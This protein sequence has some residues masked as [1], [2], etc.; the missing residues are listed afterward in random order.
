MP[1]DS[2]QP[3]HNDLLHRSESRAERLLKECT[4]QETTLLKVLIHY[5]QTKDTSDAA[6]QAIAYRTQGNYRIHDLD[7][8]TNDSVESLIKSY[9]ADPKDITAVLRWALIA[10]YRD[11][12][13]PEKS[14]K[15]DRLTRYL[16][17]SLTL[18][19]RLDN[20]V[21]PASNS[22]HLEVPEYV[23]DG[24][25]DMGAD[26]EVNALFREREKIRVDKK[27]IFSRYSGRLIQLL[28]QISESNEEPNSS[29]LKGFM[30]E[31]V[32]MSVYEALPYDHEVKAGIRAAYLGKS[33]ALKQ[34]SEE[35]LAVCRHHALETQVLLQT[36]GITSQ[37]LKCDVIFPRSSGGHAA[38]LV[39]LNN[40]WYLLDTTNPEVVDGNQ[41]VYLKSLPGVVENP[42]K[43]ANRHVWNLDSN[44]GPRIYTLRRN[45]F[46]RIRDNVL[47]AVG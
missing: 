36:L 30:V 15:E 40:S 31:F 12:K 43:D 45:M 11:A 4:L 22:V 26:S 8:V 6:A 32:A 24:L 19:V 5:I 29:N 23:P 10:I 34:V 18:Q 42:Y 3:Q 7:S 28:Q 25:S 13:I 33:M 1:Y 14:I 20:L 9:K 41:K 21:F 38:N 2:P 35:N 27:E 44:K 47:D 46:Y 37:L 17:S 16:Q 39:R